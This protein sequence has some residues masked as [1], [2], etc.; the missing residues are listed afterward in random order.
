MTTATILGEMPNNQT[1][2]ECTK[3][4]IARL[5]ARASEL[6]YTQFLVP[7]TNLG[8]TAALFVLDSPELKLVALTAKHETIAEELLIRSICNHA[9]STEQFVSDRNIIDRASLVL[10]VCGES[11]DD[12]VEYAKRKQKK[13]IIFDPTTA[14]YKRE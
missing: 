2:K 9:Y 6:G 12:A 3:I 10:I 1:D 7:T 13:V 8:I 14:E 5:V 4:A 11:T